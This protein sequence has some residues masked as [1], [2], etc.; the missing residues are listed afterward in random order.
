MKR[1]RLLLPS[2][3]IVHVLFAQ[4]LNETKL[5]NKYYGSDA[6]WYVRNTPFF[7]C[8]DTAIE[9]VYYYRWKLYKAHIRN[10]GTNQYVIT[11]FI[12]HVAWDRDP[13]C[14]I[15][16]ASMHHLYEGR[17]LRDDRYINGYI[18][19]LYRDGG[20]NRRYSESIADAAYA[21]FLVSN[22]TAF[23][24]QHLDSMK[25]IY[26]A[27]YDHYDSSKNLFWIPAMPDATEYTIASIDATNGTEGFDHGEAFRPTVNS[28]M[29][30]N[31]LAIAK[32]A[33]M[34]GDKAAADTFSRRASVLKQLV[35]R[36]LWNEGLQHFTDRF[37][38]DNQYVHYW[39]FIR[40]RELAG[41][42]PWYF[43]LP[44]DSRRYNAAW[45]HVLDTSQLLG[46]FGFRTNEPSY[47]YYFKQFVYFQGQR[48]SQW[49]GPSWPYQN[50]IVLTGMANLLQDY[51]QHDASNASYLDLLRRFTRQ[52][53]LP[54]G[55]LNLV[56]DYDPN[57]GGPIVHYYWSNHYLHS[58]YNNLVISGLCGIKPATGDT[59]G[60]HPLVDE[61]I[62]WF[63]LQGLSYHGHRLTVMYDRKGDHYRKGKG[64]QVWVDGGLKPVRHT[65][66][67]YKVY[68]GQTIPQPA[69]AARTNYALN[70]TKTGFPKLSASVN[71]LT[72]TLYQ[73][74]DGRIWYFPEITNYWSTKGSLASTDWLQIDFEKPV[75]FST[76]KLY[77]VVN[78]NGMALPD[79]ILIQTGNQGHWRTVKVISAKALRANAENT[80]TLPAGSATALRLRVVHPAKVV[81]FG[82]VEVY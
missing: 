81:A 52:H 35:Q 2:L 17:W 70:I 4:V 37:K 77:P 60:I 54:N 6:A 39:D 73:A 66:N 9:Q 21:R 32:A 69:V 26:N 24:L 18:N 62:S 23:L 48:G 16:A 45:R 78:G 79:S 29:Y 42:A 27:W 38:Q 25:A 61:S 13:Y 58:S 72:D 44:D 7:E 28:Y 47:E 41:M 64:L 82:E 43:N 51:E 67:E 59:L 19:N 33:T 20:N 63:C 5:A 71:N 74:T 75:A 76:V 65:G 12:N 57:L 56:E 30:G 50:S 55:G 49:N 46:P 3:C 68:V 15:N 14:T 40:G 1:L 80:A 31:A 22:D 34:A 53:Y 10:V 36:D 11:E 8:A